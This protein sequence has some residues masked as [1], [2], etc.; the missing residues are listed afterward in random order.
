VRHL[1]ALAGREIEDG[2][3]QG[4]LAVGPLPEVREGDP[5]RSG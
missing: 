1:R 2:D 3:L 4:V 5:T